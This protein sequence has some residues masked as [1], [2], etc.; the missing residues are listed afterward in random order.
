M[1]RRHW[2]AAEDARAAYVRTFDVVN[3]LDLWAS[4]K[5]VE[6]SL[7]SPSAQTLLEQQR[8]L[9]DFARQYRASIIDL[10]ADAA[11]RLT[12][13]GVSADLVGNARLRAAELHR[14]LA[15]A[16]GTVDYASKWVDIQRTMSAS[17]AGLPSW[18]DVRR[19]TAALGLEH[20]LARHLD[21]I[22]EFDM[23]LRGMLP[24]PAHLAWATH[25]RVTALPTVSFLGQEWRKPV[26]L[27]TDLGANLGAS[28]AWLG[29][30]RAEPMLMAAAITPSAKSRDGFKVVVADELLCLLCENP[31]IIA[32]SNLKWIGARRAVRQ[33]FVLPLCATC[34]ATERDRPGFLYE[35]LCELTRPGVVIRGV[36]RG[37]GQG[38]GQ[39]R[40]VLRLVR[41]EG[42]DDKA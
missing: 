35:A 27:L 23:V 22:R 26:G 30:Q 15:E 29:R 13:A 25:L 36:I 12:L 32:G 7:L 20:V 28:V 42:N 18:D 8:T 31:L 5:Q 1:L 33:R 14:H 34:W 21:Q 4:A 9:E 10:G 37:G 40:G 39:P 41:T 6:N 19:M 17:G 24:E 11:A 38:D 3:A 2:V 16:T